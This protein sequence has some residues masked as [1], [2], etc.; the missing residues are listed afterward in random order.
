MKKTLKKGSIVGMI[1]RG[2]ICIIRKWCR[3]LICEVV[4]C[5]VY[6]AVDFHARLRSWKVRGNDASVTMKGI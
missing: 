1:Y 4:C 2:R 3:F 6:G 5:L